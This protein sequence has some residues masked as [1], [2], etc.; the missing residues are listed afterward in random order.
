M[1][2]SITFK[3]EE[4]TDLYYALAT[5]SNYYEDMLKVAKDRCA[6]NLIDE[7]YKEYRKLEVRYKETTKLKDKVF[8]L[9]YRKNNK[10][11]GIL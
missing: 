1:R 11:G 8:A 4:L 6:H 5:A 10:N 9:L 2:N 3:G 7:N